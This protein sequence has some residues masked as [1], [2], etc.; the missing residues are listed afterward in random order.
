MAETVAGVASESGRGP[1]GRRG[2]AI[3]GGLS[4]RAEMGSL[5]GRR[6]GLGSGDKGRGGSRGVTV[7]R[8]ALGGR[9][10]AGSAAMGAEEVG[11]GFRAICGVGGCTG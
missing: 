7:G 10:T 5:S 11:R 4:G 9:G 3:G 2:G 8:A 1:R 6:A